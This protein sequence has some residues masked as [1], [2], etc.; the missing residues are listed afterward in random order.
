MLDKTPPP[1]PLHKKESKQNRLYKA[2]KSTQNQSGHKSKE[3]KRE[4]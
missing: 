3:L 2:R 4:G 1:P